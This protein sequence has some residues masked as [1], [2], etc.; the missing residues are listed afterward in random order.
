[1]RGAR[2]DWSDADS[3]RVWQAPAVAAFLE[4]PL[5]GVEEA[6]L[7]HD[8]WARGLDLAPTEA[9]LA[10]S[11]DAQERPQLL[12]GVYRQKVEVLSDVLLLSARS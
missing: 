5:S 7:I 11:L 12:A 3:W 9:F 2:A 1:M 4:E 8:A 6:S 10:S